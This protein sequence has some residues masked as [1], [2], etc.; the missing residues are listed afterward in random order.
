MLCELTCKPLCMSLCRGAFSVLCQDL[1]DLRKRV[2][3]FLCNLALQIFSAGS[4]I[5]F[6]AAVPYSFIAIV[7]T[8]KDLWK[9]HL[10]VQVPKII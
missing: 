2:R 10:A 5:E 4:G 6:I 1:V 8:L 9:T 3:Y 7:E